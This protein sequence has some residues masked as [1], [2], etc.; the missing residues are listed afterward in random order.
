MASTCSSRTPSP[1]W[2]PEPVPEQS[3]EKMLKKAYLKVMIGVLIFV[4]VKAYLV[5]TQTSSPMHQYYIYVTL[6]L[7]T[8]LIVGLCYTPTLEGVFLHVS[9]A[10]AC[11]QV[12]MADVMRMVEGGRSYLYFT[13]VTSLLAFAN[14]P[15]RL[16]LLGMMYIVFWLV[17]SGLELRLRFGLLDLDGMKAYEDRV[18][19][20]DRPPC[21]DSDAIT[22]EVVMPVLV[23][24]LDFFSKRKIQQAVLNEQKKTVQAVAAVQLIADRLVDFDLQA[25]ADFLEAHAACMP[26]EMI[27]SFCALLA[28]LESYHPYIPSELFEQGRDDHDGNGT[29]APSSVV[30]ATAN[31]GVPGTAERHVALAFTDIRSST[32]LWEASGEAMEEALNLHNE[33]LRDALRTH[34]GYEAKTIGDAFMIAFHSSIEAVRF[35]VDAQTLLA[36]MDWPEGLTRPNL[37]DGFKVLSVRMGIHCGDAAAQMNSLTH[38]YDYFGPTV[39]RA[40]RVEPFGAPGAV[41]VTADVVENIGGTEQ[42][43]KL[44]TLIPYSEPRSGKG[45]AEPLWLTAV[46]PKALVDTEERVRGMVDTATNELRRERRVSIASVDEIIAVASKRQSAAT[47]QCAS[48]VSLGSN[49]ERSI[50]GRQ[51]SIIS[52]LTA[53]DSAGQ[54]HIRSRRSPGTREASA[55]V[56]VVRF[57]FADLQSGSQEASQKAS[58]CLQAV[59]SAVHATAGYLSCVFSS[60]AVISW[61]LYNHC[62]QY[63][64][65]SALCMLK[66]QQALSP[67][68][69]AQI[70]KSDDNAF[71]SQFYAGLATGTLCATELGASLS[72]KF[73]TPFGPSVDLALSLCHGASE[74]K[75]SVLVAAISG[76]GMDSHTQLGHTRPIEQWEVFPPGEMGKPIDVFELEINSLRKAIEERENV[77]KENA[78]RQKGR[79]RGKTIRGASS[80][81]VKQSPLLNHAFARLRP[82]EPA[83]NATDQLLEV[84]VASRK[85][86]LKFAAKMVA[87]TSSKK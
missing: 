3:S 51:D 72:R 75:K 23:L 19:Y 40:A 44:G 22:T 32:A 41:T 21:R 11:V 62:P 14:A 16:R 71:E 9:V 26:A 25:A 65:E 12:S 10:V 13:L 68:A 61:G 2:E 31:V 15:E 28:N 33:A 81:R 36:T 54:L 8:G 64:N 42:L 66:I 6:A 48:P 35:G 34:N 58:R 18:A 67:D 56:G 7:V 70:D 85:R 43:A 52:V 55:C 86:R 87:L 73:L 1:K 53:H 46:L 29:D 17:F 82:A 24:V 84:D 60:T 78:G 76:S 30:S 45:L 59:F 49:V 4:G 20:C 37:D 74:L 83:P 47:S 5:H 27:V 38:R 69:A 57:H 50:L 80:S 63:L 79:A 77:V 39:N